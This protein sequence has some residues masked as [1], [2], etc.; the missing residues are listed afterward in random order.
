MGEDNGGEGEV[1][2]SASLVSEAVFS[3]VIVV[4]VLEKPDDETGEYDKA[5][6]S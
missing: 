3:D 6:G 1:E 5:A 4:P 2:Y